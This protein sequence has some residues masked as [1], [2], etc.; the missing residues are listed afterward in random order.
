MWR[1]RRWRRY[2]ATGDCNESANVAARTATANDAE[3]DLSI[4]RFYCVVFRRVDL[5]RARCNAEGSYRRID[6]AVHAG[7]RCRNVPR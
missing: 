4:E 3:R 7:S 6:S 5:G 2:H 1:W